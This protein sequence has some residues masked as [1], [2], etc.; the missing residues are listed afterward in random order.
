MVMGKM[1]QDYDIASEAKPEDVIRLFRSVIP[2]GIKHGTV[3]VRFKGQSIE[4]TTF[5]TD[6]DYQDGR[7]PTSVSFSTDI[8]QD[9]MRRDFSMNALALNCSTGELLDLHGGQIDIQAKLIRA[10]GDPRERFSEDGLRPLR[11]IRFASVLGFSIE[12]KTFAAISECLDKVAKVSMERVRDEFSKILL[13]PQPGLGLSL[14]QASGILGLILPELS[15]LSA[16]EQ[17]PPHHFNALEHSFHACAGSQPHLE[18]RLAALFHDLGKKDCRLIREDGSVAFHGHEKRSAEVSG[19]LLRRL[20]YP[21]A[22]IEKV[23]HLVLH[24]MTRYDDSWSDAAV[25][26][27]ISRVGPQALADLLDLLEADEYGLE[28][29]SLA[30]S[31]LWKFRERIAKLLATDSALSIKDLAINGDDLAAIGLARGRQMGL[32]LKELLEAVLED[33]TLNTKE[34]LAEIAVKLG[35]K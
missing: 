27:F 21:N 28:G 20:K 17:S 16:I 33:P 8:R 11:A 30:G 4:V 23:C 18:L 24:H 31:G 26:R 1:A 32:I 34:K 15:Q 19:A 9:L 13:G 29:R 22:V 25:R 35:E 6:A 3:T 2:T 7:H 14:L 10:I 5:R 12:E